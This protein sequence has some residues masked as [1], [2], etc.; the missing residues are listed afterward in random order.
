MTTIFIGGVPRSGTTLMQSILCADRTTNPMLGEPFYF[1]KIVYAYKQTKQEFARRGGGFFGDP[2]KLRQFSADWVSRFLDQVRANHPGVDNLVI[3]EPLLTRHF[4]EVAELLP[5]ARLVVMVRDPRDVI[6]SMIRVAERMGTKGTV[7]NNMAPALARDLDIL[8]ESVNSYY[9]ELLRYR[10]PGVRRNLC[11]V[12]YEAVVGETMEALDKI[13]AFTGLELSDYRPEHD[14]NR[15]GAGFAPPDPDD[16]W[17]SALWG[18]PITAAPIGEY[19]TTLTGPEITTI[20][21]DCAL[22]FES[23]GYPCDGAARR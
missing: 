4:I 1:R 13:R 11:F 15:N 23:F 14:W 19:R 16:P 10:A 12:F 5:D 9:R 21:R 20:E 17:P 18:R 6:G 2:D 8:C 3:K 7:P 22:L